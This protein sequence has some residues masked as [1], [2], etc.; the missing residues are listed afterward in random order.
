MECYEKGLITKE[1]A[2]RLDLR[3]GNWKVA[4]QMVENIARR[5]GLGDIL[6]DGPVRAANYIGKGSEKFI[7]HVKGM[8][9]PMHDHKAAYGSA[10]QYAIG[11]A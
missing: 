10:L 6:A 2:G 9:L 4:F 3:F 7:V 11:S 8:P 1:Y 5:E